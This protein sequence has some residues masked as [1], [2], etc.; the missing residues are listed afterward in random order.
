MDFRINLQIAI[1]AGRRVV[2][3]CDLA[4]LSSDPRTLSRATSS[5]P[6]PL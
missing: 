3:V 5:W 4:D 2:V 6:N 1:G